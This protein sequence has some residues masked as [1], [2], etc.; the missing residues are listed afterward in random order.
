MK[1][2][3]LAI[4]F[5]LTLISTAF[6]ASGGMQPGL[7]EIIATVQRTGMPM[8]MPAQTTRRCLTQKDLDGNRAVP[9]GDDKNCQVKDYKRKGNTATWTIVC[10]GKETMTGTGTMTFSSTSYTGKMKSKM[11]DGSETME[12]THNWAA[13]RIGDCKK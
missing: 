2:I 7:W 6:A 11:K 4:L 10:T 13:K 3:A 1:R 12:M 5:P 8:S 9:Q